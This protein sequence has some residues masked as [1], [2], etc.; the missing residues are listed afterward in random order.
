MKRGLEHASA[1]RGAQRHAATERA[2]REA[3]QRLQA[4][5]PI[6]PE[7]RDH[8][9]QLSVS[10]ICVEARRSRNALYKGHPAL[11]REIRA[12]IAGKPH[13][14]DRDRHAMRRDSIEAT[15]AERRA[16]RQR[17]ISENAALLLRA[18]K[19]EEALA[20]IKRRQPL[21]LKM[22]DYTREAS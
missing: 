3:W 20:R 13:V 21:A 6:H 18:L 19:A 8:E 5:M 7:L 17:L 10:A 14:E 9:W 16:D 15:L 12:A 22:T 1:E 11:L 2:F 4:G